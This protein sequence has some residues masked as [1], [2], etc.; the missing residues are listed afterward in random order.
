MKLLTIIDEDF[1][2]YKKPSM[3]LGCCYCDWKC[4]TE[5]GL[6]LSTCQNHPWK[7][8]EIINISNE[9]LIQRYLTNTITHAIIFGGLEPLILF[10]EVLNF[11]KE[12]RKHSEDDCVLYTGYYPEEIQSEINELKQFE[13]II[14]KVGRYIPNHIP[15]EDEVLGVKLASDNQYG[16]KLS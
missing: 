13:N 16:I 11:I 9:K 3:F 2:N 14:L 6:P 10:D 5:Q 8:S 12:F 15:H 4:C 1:T 7:D